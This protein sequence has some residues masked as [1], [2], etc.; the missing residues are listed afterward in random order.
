[1]GPEKH[2]LDGVHIP[3]ERSNFEGGGASPAVI[4]AKTAEAIEMPLGC[5]LRWAKFNRIRQ[6]Q[7]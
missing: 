6:N 1:M 2:V 5:G 4:C 7:M 3:M